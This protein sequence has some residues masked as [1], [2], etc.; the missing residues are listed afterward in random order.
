MRVDTWR[1]VFGWAVQVL[2]MATTCPPDAW[3]GGAL[4]AWLEK[5]NTGSRYDPSVERVESVAQ[6]I[7]GIYGRK[8]PGVPFE[9]RS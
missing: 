8:D 2:A 6:L 7:D 9:P 5:L 1:H 3:G 4:S